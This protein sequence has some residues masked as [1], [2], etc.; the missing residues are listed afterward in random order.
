MNEVIEEAGKSDIAKKAGQFT[1]DIGKT[2]HTIS[3]KAQELG[4]TSA[5]QSISEATK[6]VQNEMDTQSMQGKSMLF[7]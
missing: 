6:A 5:F 4:K 2:A 3:E 7:L 1:E